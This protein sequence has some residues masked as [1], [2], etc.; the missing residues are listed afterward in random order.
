MGCQALL[1]RIFPTQGSD[2]GLLPGRQILYCLSFMHEL[3]PREWIADLSSS[4]YL[5][6]LSIGKINK[7]T[8]IETLAP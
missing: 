2:P 5:V 3:G 6:S 4:L 8:D 7:Q 1:Q